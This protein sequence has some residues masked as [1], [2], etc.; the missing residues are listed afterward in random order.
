[1]LRNRIGKR[2][3]DLGITSRDVAAETIMGGILNMMAKEE[4]KEG[5]VIETFYY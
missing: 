2:D 5:L 3:P 1:M 4:A